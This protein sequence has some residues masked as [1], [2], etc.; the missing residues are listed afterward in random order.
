MEG[1]FNHPI[2][3]V[4]EE[5]KD[6]YDCLGELYLQGDEVGESDKRSIWTLI[7]RGFPPIVYIQMA[8]S[9]RPHYRVCA[10]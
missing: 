9:L 4:E 6:L 7:D 5:G 8:V 10:D 1:V 3:G 2:V